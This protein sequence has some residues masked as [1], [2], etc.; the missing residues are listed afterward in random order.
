MPPR[1]QAKAKPVKMPILERAFDLLREV[2]GASH[3][4][5]GGLTLQELAHDFGLTTRT[6]QRMISAMQHFAE[7]IPFYQIKGRDNRHR[8]FLEI[9]QFIL[10]L[11]KI[12]PRAPGPP[13]KTRPTTRRSKSPKEPEE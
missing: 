7:P 9:G 2:A 3:H 1:A 6:V 11:Q 10:Q 13:E 12:R 5:D 8:W 4:A